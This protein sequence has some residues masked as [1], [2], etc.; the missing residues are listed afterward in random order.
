[1]RRTAESPSLIPLLPSLAIGRM[2]GGIP[3]S[4]YTEYHKHLPKSDPEEEYDLRSDLYIL[5]HYLNHTVI[6][7]VG[8]CFSDRVPHGRRKLLTGRLRRWCGAED[9]Q[10]TSCIS[11]RVKG[12]SCLFSTFNEC[13][14]RRLYID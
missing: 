10:A 3:S 1:M 11:T 6:F 14:E 7:G 5:F 12:G 2:F 4:F 8:P 9:G 13:N